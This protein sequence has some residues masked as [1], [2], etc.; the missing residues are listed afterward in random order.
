[1]PVW[2]AM[3]IR[4]GNNEI[5][6][7]FSKYLVVGGSNFFLNLFIYIVLIWLFPSH[8]LLALTAA[9]FAGVVF[10]YAV[11]FLWVFKPEESLVFRRRFPKYFLIYLSTYL[12]NMLALEYFVTRV[13]MDP[14]YIQFMI[15]PFIVVL[16]FTGSKFISLNKEQP[17]A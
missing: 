17:G 5:Y 14:L 2:R 9:W 15:I 3:S 11:N 1:M 7:Q 16:N 4:N 6:S 8:Y 10:T 13:R 12:L